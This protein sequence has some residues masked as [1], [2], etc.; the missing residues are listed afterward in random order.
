M[1]LF[2]TTYFIED[3]KGLFIS[4]SIF[5]RM[6]SGMGASCFITPFYAY[7]PLLYPNN[8]EKMIGMCEISSGIG[9]LVGITNNYNER[10]S[11]RFIVV[12]LG[13]VLNPIHSVWNYFHRNCAYHLF[14]HQR[15]SFNGRVF[16]AAV[17][18]IK[19]SLNRIAP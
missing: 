6:M 15:S 10:T 13:R 4:V 7:I 1:Y 18:R 9:F 14:F 11:D 3:N 16:Y 17:C 19:H 5:A 2:G 8:I 12:Q